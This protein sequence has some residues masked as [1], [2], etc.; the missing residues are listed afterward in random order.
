MDLLDLFV[1]VY[2]RNEELI[3]YVTATRILLLC[4]VNFWVGGKIDW[5]LDSSASGRIHQ[6]TMRQ[7]GIVFDG[8]YITKIWEQLSDQKPLGYHLAYLIRD[9]EKSCGININGKCV[10]F[11]QGTHRKCS[12]PIQDELRQMGITVV[13]YDL[14]L[15]N[16]KRVE[17]GTD[18][19]VALA[20]QALTTEGL[21]VILV[22]GDGDFEPLVTTDSSVYICGAASSLSD[23]LKDN[24]LLKHDG[25]VYDLDTEIPR[26]MYENI[27]WIDDD[28]RVH[29]NF[30][31]PFAPS[32]ETYSRMT[33][34]LIESPDCPW[35]STHGTTLMR[36]EIFNR[37]KKENMRVYRE[38]GACIVECDDYYVIINM[39][40]IFYNAAREERLK[41][42]KER[43]ERKKGT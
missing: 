23:T 2:H 17:R 36:K 34:K 43:L 12:T 15:T 10:Q 6:K 19:G 8:T 31:H 5:C 40:P 42:I 26:F 38:I 35:I 29:I 24:L 25:Q 37:C 32:V 18:V 30:A 14:K 39:R 27:S 11:H 1:I 28:D 7:Y 20:V 3:E 4:H 13:N 41:K 21:G 22:T 9:I 33:Q 16:S